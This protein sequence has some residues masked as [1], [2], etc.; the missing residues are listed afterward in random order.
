MALATLKYR[1]S[2]LAPPRTYMNMQAIHAGRMRFGVGPGLR[3]LRSGL[4]YP[5]V[6]IPAGSFVQSAGVVTR[7]I[8]APATTVDVG[9]DTRVLMG[10]VSLGTVGFVSAADASAGLGYYP[11][12]TT[13]YM[14]L[15]AT[16]T[17][18]AADIIIR[19][20]PYED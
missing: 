5:I 15:S 20:Y 12:E 8:F 11:D 2:S 6:T 19:F 7:T 18:G 17:A 9:T 14:S 16:P 4:G 3:S 13:L 10:G 1:A